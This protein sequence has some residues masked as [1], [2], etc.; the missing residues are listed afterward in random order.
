MPIIWREMN[1]E[2]THWSL[3]GVTDAPDTPAQTGSDALGALV[4]FAS[5]FAN[6]CSANYAI[7]RMLAELEPQAEA[8]LQGASGRRGVVAVVSYEDVHHPDGQSGRMVRGAALDART[9]PNP[10]VAMQTIRREARR[11][12]TISAGGAT[13]AVTPG[14]RYFWGEHVSETE[15]APIVRQR[16][17][18]RVAPTMRGRWSRQAVREVLRPHGTAR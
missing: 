14:G 11:Y 6:Q 13:P 2:L 12:G 10:A 15:L 7:R 16:R 8:M 17:R 4:Q 9:F 18:R 3:A 5:R 1:P